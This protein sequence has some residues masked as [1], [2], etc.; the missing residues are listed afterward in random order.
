MKLTNNRYYFDFNATSPLSQSV[1]DWGKGDFFC[2]NPASFHQSGR[3]AK[4]LINQTIDFLFETFHLPR[5][6]FWVFFHSGATESI[7]TMIKGR[8]E[9]LD[10]SGEKSQ[11]WHS[12]VDHSTA[13]NL[14]LKLAERGREV[15]SFNPKSNGDF[16]LQELMAKAQKT[17]DKVLC[18]F[19]NVNNE[20]GIHWPLEVASELKKN[21]HVSIHVDAVQSV[22]KIKDWNKLD[23]SLDAYTFSGHKFG[24]HKGVGFTFVKKDFQFEALLAGG[25]QQNG[26]RSGTENPFGVY[27]LKLALEDMLNGF[28]YTE[29]SKAH[30]LIEESL[31]ELLSEKGG[32]IGEEATHR[33]VTTCFIYVNGQKSNEI[34]TA[35]DMAGIEISS[36]SACSSGAQIE[37]T[38]AKVLGLPPESWYST[39]RLSFSPFMTVSD[40]RDYVEKISH[41]LKRFL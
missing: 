35:F 13:R 18:N 1:K 6:K 5:D 8:L 33:N 19:L 14:G 9:H 38:Q 41:V 4:K 26:L 10:F 27:S 30:A 34:M 20:T 7:N 3:E 36:G 24:A 21:A 29:V 11:F 17:S 23:P 12:R 39:L 28:Q 16:P 40:A 32:I 22:G 31:R 25:G 37:N 15:T 2:A